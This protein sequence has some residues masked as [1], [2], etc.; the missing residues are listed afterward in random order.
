MKI[1]DLVQ[2]DMQEMGKSSFKMDQ[3]YTYIRAKRISLLAYLFL[4]TGPI[5]QTYKDA[6]LSGRMKF[7]A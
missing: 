4:N 5:S 1:A 2:M 6:G 7:D 3:A